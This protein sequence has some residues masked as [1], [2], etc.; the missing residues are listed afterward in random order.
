MEKLI[1]ECHEHCCA[2]VHLGG[3]D[4]E[5]DGRARGTREG[6]ANTFLKSQDLQEHPWFK[7]RGELCAPTRPQI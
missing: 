4:V 7:Y 6:E 3:E 1:Q 2:R 5:E